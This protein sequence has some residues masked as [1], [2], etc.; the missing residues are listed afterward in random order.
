MRK[1]LMDIIDQA[2]QVSGWAF[3]T[4]LVTIFRIQK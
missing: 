3:K 1:D 2:M 4:E